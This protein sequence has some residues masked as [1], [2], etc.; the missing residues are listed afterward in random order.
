MTASAVARPPA[1]V[2]SLIGIAVLAIVL[3]YVAI[4]AL[5]ARRLEAANQA[6]DELAARMP[7]VQRLPEGAAVLVGPG[8]PPR[9]NDPRWTTGPSAPF[10][11]TLTA[12]PWGNAYVLN[13]AAPADAAVWLLSAG[14]DG[15]IETPFVQ[16]AA[17]ATTLGD[18]LAHRLTAVPGR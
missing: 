9:S 10:G 14:P 1:L 4:S 2:A 17:N 6:L 18:D 5:H 15:I 8:S 13:A 12:D 3:P 7:S 16:P 11:V